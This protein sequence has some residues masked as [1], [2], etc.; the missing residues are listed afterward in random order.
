MS[1]DNKCR[2]AANIIFKKKIAVN[3][4]QNNKVNKARDGMT[5]GYLIYT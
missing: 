2:G 4:E 3:S 1:I 5:T